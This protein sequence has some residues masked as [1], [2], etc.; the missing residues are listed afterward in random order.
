MSIFKTLS[1]A[2]ILVSISACGVNATQG[3]V[4]PPA[5]TSGPFGM[6]THDDIT[7]EGDKAFSGVHKV[8]IGAFK[9]GFITAKE[10][11]E[12]AGTGMGGRSNAVLELQGLTPAVMQE[13]TDKAY[14]DLLAKLKADGY[15]VVDRAQLTGSTEFAK[16]THEAS[17]LTEESSFFGSNNDVTYVAPKDIGKLYFFLGD[18]GPSGGFGF[19]NPTTAASTFAEQAKLPV[20]SVSYTLDFAS[21]NG[22]GGSFASTSALEVGQALSVIPGS[23]IN[24]IGGAAGTFSN[25]NGSLKL[26]QAITSPDAFGE[27]EMTTSE[28]MKV[29]ETASNVAGVL[30]GAGTNQSRDF[31]VKADPARYSSGA[32]G[33]LQKANGDLLQRMQALR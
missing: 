9:V 3:V 21:K 16:A 20:L 10:E 27:I 4:K 13:I 26:G 7:T 22:S 25:A 17:P 2:A 29:L 18:T 1:A 6:I 15:E 23:G 32:G 28:T 30:L 11:Q 24:L 8:V 33:I 31:S 14:S 12:K 19:D 5:Q